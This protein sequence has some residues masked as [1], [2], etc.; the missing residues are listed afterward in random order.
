[1]S[2]RCAPRRARLVRSARGRAQNKSNVVMKIMGRSRGLGCDSRAISI[3]VIRVITW[4]RDIQRTARGAAIFAAGQDK[5]KPASKPVH[6]P[7]LLLAV[8]AKL[9]EAW[10]VVSRRSV[11]G[12]ARAVQRRSSRHLKKRT[13]TTHLRAARRSTAPKAAC[14]RPQSPQLVRSPAAR[15]LDRRARLKR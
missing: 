6:P 4:R 3:P 14:R 8:P 2:R 5:N 9:A 12:L 10:M 13:L 11:F 1:M 15:L 7:A